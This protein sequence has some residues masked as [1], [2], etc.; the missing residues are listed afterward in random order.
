MVM[1]DLE[2]VAHH[3]AAHGCLFEAFTIPVKGLAISE[4]YGHCKIVDEWEYDPIALARREY[5]LQRAICVC[6]G[7]ATMDKVRG[8]KPKDDRNWWASSDD[9]AQAL[10][11]CLKLA[12]GDEVAAEYLLAYA[13]RR[14][15][16][17]VE[18]HWPEIGR[19]AYGLLVHERLTGEQ[20]REIIER[21]RAKQL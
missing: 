13:L 9:R 14:A 20:V 4:K 15:E 11:C 2:R 3:E 18:Q 5:L 12:G 7:R 16:I 19:V 17:L 8:Y 21:T 1:C 10:E 6:A